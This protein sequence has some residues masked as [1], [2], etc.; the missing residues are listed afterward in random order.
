MSKRHF[1]SALLVILSSLMLFLNGCSTSST[2]ANSYQ[3]RSGDTLYSIAFK[4][5]IDYKT[6]ARLNGISSPYKIYV[7]QILKIGSDANFATSTYTVKKGDSLSLI[8][9]RYKSNVKTLASLNGLHSP[10]T[11]YIGQKLKIAPSSNSGAVVAATPNYQPA[12]LPKHVSIN[13]SKKT[14]G[15]IWSWPAN[16]TITSGYS[17]AELGN[18]GVTI[19]GQRHQAI[20]AAADGEVVYAGNALRGYGNLV[21]LNHPGNYISAYAHN[22]SILVKEG[23]RVKRGQ[24][25]A[26]MGSTD[27]DK[28]KLLFEL[29]HEGQTV[30]PLAYLPAQ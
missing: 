25:I 14:A 12:P 18:P 1:Y 19:A 13:Q 30:D 17:D 8:A 2:P 26:T 10:Y 5:G 21:I 27:T 22:E 6:L 16:G 24:N 7:G 3:V 11:L 15:I 20:K 9:Q 23:Q 28:V 29:R 4:Y